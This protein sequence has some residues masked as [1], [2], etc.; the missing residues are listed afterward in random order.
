VLLGLEPRLAGFVPQHVK[1]LCLRH[2]NKLCRRAGSGF[3]C[4]R[5]LASLVQR[6]ITVLEGG[7]ELIGLRHRLAGLDHGPRPARR[8]PGRACHLGAVVEPAGKRGDS[9]CRELLGPGIRAEQSPRGIAVEELHVEVGVGFLERVDCVLYECHF[10]VFIMTIWCDKNECVLAERS[11][12]TLLHD[13]RRERHPV[14][15][16]RRIMQHVRWS[17]S[18][19]RVDSRSPRRRATR[20]ALSARSRRS[21]LLKSVNSSSDGWRAP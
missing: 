7:T 11:T 18:R 20:V 10:H 9:V 4:G 17:C 5:D 2:L 1:R 6:D 16:R 3:L 12:R 21:K 13:R 8:H 14:A 19:R 15:D